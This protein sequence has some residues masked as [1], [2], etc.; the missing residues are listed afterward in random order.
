VADLARWRDRISASFDGDDSVKASCIHANDG[1]VLVWA[2][3]YDKPGIEINFISAVG[4]WRIRIADFSFD[5][6]GAPRLA[7][8]APYTGLGEG[9]YET[10]EFTAD[11]SELLFTSSAGSG[12]LSSDIYALDIDTGHTRQLTWTDYNE[13]AHPSPDGKWITWMTNA[14]ITGRGADL[15]IMNPLGGQQTRL[16]YFNDNNPFTASVN[17][18]DH[19]WSPDSHHIVQYV[20]TEPDLGP[21]VIFTLQ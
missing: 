17:L 7:I 6:S 19:E 13:H 3:K 9:F 4:C 2:E 8:R 18:A 11:D 5:S 12:V 15:W 1:R 14:G 10:H 20:G 21:I 16:T